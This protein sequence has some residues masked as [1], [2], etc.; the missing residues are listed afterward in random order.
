MALKQLRE[1]KEDNLGGNNQYF[2]IINISLLFCFVSLVKGLERTGFKLKVALCLDL[3]IIVSKS[4]MRCDHENVLKMICYQ[5][6]GYRLRVILWALT[7]M[8]SHIQL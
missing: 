8:A 6:L 3:L 5:S 1:I 4:N 7:C 2:L